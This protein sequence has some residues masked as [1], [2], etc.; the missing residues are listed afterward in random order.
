MMNTFYRLWSWFVKSVGNTA[1]FKFPL[2]VIYSPPGYKFKGDGL[3]DA[4]EMTMQE[5]LEPG[6]ILLRKHDYY[7]SSKL[8]PGDYKHGGVYVG[9]LN[10]KRHTVVHALSAGIISENIINFFRADY[11]VVIRPRLPKG[12]RQAAADKAISCIGKP[13]DFKFD[14]MGRKA[15]DRISCTELVFLSYKDVMPIEVT[16]QGIYGFRKQSVI[17]DSILHTDSQII[18]ATQNCSNLP[19][20]QKKLVAELEYHR[21]RYICNNIWIPEKLN[22]NK[23][24]GGKS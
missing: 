10:G 9:K 12:V 7:T 20:F 4:V 2:W 15:S 11:L 14:F 16:L 24:T 17:A 21:Q 6:D 23:N 8:I 13:Y 1:I 19:S 3:Y 22:T 5:K 18:F